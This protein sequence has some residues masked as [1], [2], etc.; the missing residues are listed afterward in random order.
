MLLSPPLLRAQLAEVI[1]DKEAQG[2]IVTGLR[3]RLAALPDS[4]DALVDFAHRLADLPLR[5][6][7]P[8]VEPNELDAIWAECDPDR[9]IGVVGVVDLE[10]SARRVETAFLGSVCGC[11]LGKPLE[12]SPTLDEIR[13]ALDSVGEWPLND[14]VSERVG[15]A[16]RR[17]HYSWTATV[18]ERIAYVA[19]DDDINY[20]IMGMLLIEQHGV[21]FT[22]RQVRDA[23][24]RH[25]P[26]GTTFGPERTLLLKAGANTLAGGDPGTLDT[27]VT[28]LNPGDEKCGALIRADAYGY[29]CPGRPALAAELAWRD[30]SWT[31][32]RTG[33]YGA[34]FV[35]AAIALAQVMNDRLG[36]FATALQF[37]PRRSRFYTIV[38]DALHEVAQASD[39]LDGYRRL[40]GKYQ[41]YGHCLIYQE[42]GTLINTL[43][44]AE[45]VGDGICK[46]VSQGNDTDS[47]GA[48][49]GSLLGAYFGPGHLDPRWLAPFNDDIHTALAWFYERSLSRLARRMGELPRRVAA[50]LDATSSPAA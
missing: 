13:T 16:L 50:E 4:Y 29:A 36:I 2:H 41:A 23:W 46:Q 22:Q 12:I 31:H 39:W 38:A 5:P 33:V 7:W 6:D 27:W 15:P 10:D 48:T 47:F 25:L 17:F 21:Q 26:I 24:L 1:A 3:D 35:A 45:S 32:R 49:A 42:V 19:P 18:R 9:P 20:T 8:H 34:M 30:A 14:Y 11:V 40:H 44:F 37:V 43:R 28:L